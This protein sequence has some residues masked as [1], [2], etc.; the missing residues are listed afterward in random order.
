MFGRYMRLTFV[1]VLL[2]VGF[3]SIGSLPA[4][5]ALEKYSWHDYKTIEAE[6][7]IY[8]VIAKTGGQPV[9]DFVQADPVQN[10]SV[11]NPSDACKGTLTISLQSDTAGT[12]SSTGQCSPFQSAD[13]AIRIDNRDVAIQSVK[14]E[15]KQMITTYNNTKCVAT[16]P[17]DHQ[18]CQ[19]LNKNVV[20][21]M[22]QDCL[23][24][25][26]YQQN[27]MHGN[28]YLDC[29]SKTLDVPR[30]GTEKP[31]E[32]DEP[33]ECTLADTGWII[34]QMDSFIAGL[35]DNTFKLLKPFFTI[36]PLGQRSDGSN[37]STYTAWESVRT[38]ANV[39]LVIAFLVI[40][41]SY[42]TGAGINMYHIKT[43]LPRLIVAAILINASFIICSLAIDTSNVV[44]VTVQDIIKKI[45]DGPT[46]ASGEF[47]SW[48]GVTKKIHSTGATEDETKDADQQNPDAANQTTNQNTNSNN[49]DD[50]DTKLTKMVVGGVEIT[51]IAVMFVQ[52]S[53][54]IPIMVMALFAMLTVLLVLL[55]RLAV[56]IVLVIISPLAFACFLLPNTK[57][58]YDRWQKLFV[59]MLILFPAI[60]LVFGAS[61]LASS[62]IRQ[63]A[64]ANGQVLLAIFSMGIQVIPLFVAPLLIKISGGVL[65]QFAGIVN[66]KRKGLYDRSM[67]R[68]QEFRGDRKA[69]RQMNAARDRTL[70]GAIPVPK[71]LNRARPINRKAVRQKGRDLANA[72]A[73]KRLGVFN[74]ENADAIRSR[75]LR[76]V[77][78][79]V[80]DVVSEALGGITTT[81]LEDIEVA[82]ASAAYARFKNDTSISPDIAMRS[83]E[84]RMY[85]GRELSEAERRAMIRIAGEGF[86]DG[87][88]EHGVDGIEKATRLVAMSGNM[89]INERRELIDTLRKNKV[90]D[91]A[92]FLG[93]SA[94]GKI[95]RGEVNSEADV[96]KLVQSAA[97]GGKFS[98]Q[99]LAGSSRS[100]LKR[101]DKNMA[102]IEPAAAAQIRTNAAN[103]LNNPN[104]SATIRTENRPHLESLGGHR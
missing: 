4:H 98:Q 13:T 85:G 40:I 59:D 89:N 74:A 5:A 53:A 94:L 56:V 46:S 38:L 15:E 69:I 7:G 16:E 77:N 82:E 12:L 37:T 75:T 76:G 58:W 3:A 20:A 39:I 79:D 43:M 24:K 10:Y 33:D 95:E 70:F 64:E 50:T 80:K 45:D 48:T 78:G 49:K 31:D 102:N 2:M 34:C 23:S 73:E 36:S 26:N 61:S 54:L 17:Q 68:A 84:T 35:T 57:R 62:V 18:N 72:E 92:A 30:P 100:T 67:N 99:A 65:N 47:A 81:K 19:N 90:G 91:K 88:D 55:L 32:P 63:T 52:L 51:G 22:Q 96:D 66:N 93:G 29:M 83:L 101:L 21:A 60:A 86:N 44:G 25:H 14:N 41:Y 11:E 6:S 9:T 27:V 104:L 28:A 8:G 87:P 42:L 103:A 97:K 1:A 71:R